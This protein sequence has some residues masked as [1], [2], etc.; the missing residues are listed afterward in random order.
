MLVATIIGLLAVIAVCNYIIARDTSRL[1]VI[2]T[3]LRDIETAKEQWA[4]EF[5]KNVGEP[6]A[7]VDLLKEYLRQGKLKVIVSETYN[8]NPI[9]TPATAALPTDTKLGPY[10]FGATIPAP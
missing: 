3:N 10:G 4:F 6:V 7:D 2:R 9:G 1:A 5:K 8:P